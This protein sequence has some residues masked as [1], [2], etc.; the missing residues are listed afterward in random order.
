LDDCFFKVSIKIAKSR[1]LRI[2]LVDST[3]TID[4]PKK[5]SEAKNQ[6]PARR[7]GRK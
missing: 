4:L 5:P 7:F 2:L 3:L 1:F 6:P